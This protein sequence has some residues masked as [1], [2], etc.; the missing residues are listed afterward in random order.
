M[1]NLIGNETGQF[2]ISL[3]FYSEDSI[4]SNIIKIS[5]MV[6]YERTVQCDFYE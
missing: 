6:S 2:S 1:L 3:L 4:F 5:R